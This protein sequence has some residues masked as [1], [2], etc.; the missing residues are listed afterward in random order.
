MFRKAEKRVRVL[1]RGKEFVPPEL[2]IGG[3]K[4]CSR[5]GLYERE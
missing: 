4:G 5:D 1:D 2:H 3:K